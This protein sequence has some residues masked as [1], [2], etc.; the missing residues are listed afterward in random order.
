MKKL[1]VTFLLVC[2]GLVGCATSN[3]SWERVDDSAYDKNSLEL[4][5]QACD[6]NRSMKKLSQ[7]NTLSL[8]KNVSR[9]PLYDE[10]EEEYEKY[11]R[12]Q[13]YDNQMKN[14]KENKKIKK[15][16]EGAYSCMK[17]KGFKHVNTT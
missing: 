7:L 11:L 10:N 17:N 15:Q 4:A 1:K 16:A 5:L 12:T 2:S 14:S 3:T 9:G 6:F 13:T 8:N